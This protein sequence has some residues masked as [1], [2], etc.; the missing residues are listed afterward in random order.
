M[1]TAILKSSS[2]GDLKLLATIAR[3]MGVK[4]K[5]LSVNN[6]EDIG[7]YNAMKQSTGKNIDVE[8]YLQK[9]KGK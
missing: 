2:E 5:M 6:A 1:K 8:K 3:K 4:F 7:L 9:L